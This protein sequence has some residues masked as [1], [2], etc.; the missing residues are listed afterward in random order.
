MCIDFCKKT[1]RVYKSRVKLHYF[2]I[3]IK[4]KTYFSCVAV[5]ESY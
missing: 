1:S 3:K 5:L 2:V 4:I